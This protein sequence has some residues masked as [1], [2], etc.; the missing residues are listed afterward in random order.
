M[1]ITTSFGETFEDRSF[2]AE[3]LKGR[4]LVAIVFFALSVGCF[5]VPWC[6]PALKKIYLV[7]VV[8][9]F[10]NVSVSAYNFW[11]A[12]NSSGLLIGFYTYYGLARPAKTFPEGRYKVMAKDCRW[13]VIRNEKRMYLCSLPFELNG[14]VREIEIRKTVQGENRMVVV[15]VE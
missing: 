3:Q 10:S 4:M 8:A 7:F 15:P 5:F 11:L 1:K 14:N 6:I 2:D 9:G 13:A 12:G